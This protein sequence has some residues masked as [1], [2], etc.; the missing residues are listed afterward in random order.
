ME[1]RCEMILA[2]LV[3]V[4]NVGFRSKVVVFSSKTSR[5][6]VGSRFSFLGGSIHV[7]VMSGR[8]SWWAFFVRSSRTFSH[9]LPAFAG[10]ADVLKAS[11]GGRGPRMTREGEVSWRSVRVWRV[12]LV[13]AHVES[14]RD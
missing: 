14:S 12:G 10:Y 9:F 11:R 3:G 4:S 5:R 8:P 6:C 13:S 1:V 2:S 7:T